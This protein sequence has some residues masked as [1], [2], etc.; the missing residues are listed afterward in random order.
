MKLLARRIAS[1]ESMASLAPQVEELDWTKITAD[2]RTWLDARVAAIPRTADGLDFSG[3]SLRD[4]RWISWLGGQCSPNHP[5]HLQDPS[6]HCSY[7]S[8]PD[9]RGVSLHD[10][11]ERVGW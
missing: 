6:C 10:S 1:L 9:T 2:E 7:C 4:L 11:S 3:V 5:K 8:P